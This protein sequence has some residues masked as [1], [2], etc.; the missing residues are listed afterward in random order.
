LVVG[1]ALVVV[2]LVVG[3][4]LVVV[5]LVRTGL[6]VILPTYISLPAQDR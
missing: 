4:A 2:D 5:D 6:V 3:T 1:T